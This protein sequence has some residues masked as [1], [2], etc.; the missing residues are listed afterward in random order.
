[1]EIIC[2]NILNP[3][4][5]TN[6]VSTMK[7]GGGEIVRTKSNKRVENEPEPHD[8]NIDGSKLKLAR[9]ELDILRNGGYTSNA[10]FDNH[11]GELGSALDMTFRALIPWFVHY[12][13]SQT[14][15]EVI[16]CIFGLCDLFCFCKDPQE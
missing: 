12:D 1:M 6:Q 13:F 10:E 8:I 15:S 9:A 2:I 7:R 11:L 5:G 14:P 16:Q 4:Q 3:N